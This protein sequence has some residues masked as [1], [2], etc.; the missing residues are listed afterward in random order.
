MSPYRHNFFL[1]VLGYPYINKARENL[2]YAPFRHKLSGLRLLAK[3]V[4]VF[5]YL[6]IV[7][8]CLNIIKL[9]RF[10]KLNLKIVNHNW[11]ITS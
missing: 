1:E 6:Y 9:N 11:L 5:L 10:L 7:M 8:F 4:R 3:T 2:K